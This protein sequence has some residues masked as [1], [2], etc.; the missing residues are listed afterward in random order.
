VPT[1]LLLLLTALQAPDPPRVGSQPTRVCVQANKAIF[2]VENPGETRLAVTLAIEHWSSSGDAEEWTKVQQDITQKE[3]LARKARPVRL[4]PGRRRDVDWN[5]KDR[6]GP[7][8][9]TT[10]RHRLVVEYF[11]EDGKRLGQVFHEFTIADCS[12]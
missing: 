5:L 1:A 12:Y 7:P 11:D 10:G 9:M 3:A 4:E 6:K 2:Q 8:P